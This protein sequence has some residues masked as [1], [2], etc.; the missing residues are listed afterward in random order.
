MINILIN[1]S[2]TSA[3]NQV[4]ISRADQEKIIRYG[5]VLKNSKEH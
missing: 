4:A 1:N 3:Q 2:P 5:N